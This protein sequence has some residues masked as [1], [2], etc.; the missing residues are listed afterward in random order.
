MGIEMH[1]NERL[2]E[3]F[4]D[5]FDSDDLTLA[6]ELKM[7]DLPE[8]DSMSHL[9]LMLCIEK[10]FDIKIPIERIETLKSVAKILDLLH[11]NRIND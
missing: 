1:M 7:A 6:P 5:V 3:I 9:R 10:E 11:E 8:W 4:R 2:Q